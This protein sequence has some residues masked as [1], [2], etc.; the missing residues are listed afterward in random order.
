MNSLKYGYEFDADDQNNTAAAIFRAAT[1][2]GP[3]VLDLGSGPAIVSRRLHEEQGRDVTCVDSDAEALESLASSG[4]RTIRADLE[5][6]DWESQLS[7]GGYDVIILADVLEHLRDP[8]ALLQRI[9]R[10]NLLADGGL[11]LI[12]VPNAAH[13]SVIAELLLGDFRYMRTGILDA[14]HVRWFTHD[15]LRRLLE[16]NGF[17]ITTV[18]RT[19]RT[20]E[21]TASFDRA[22]QVPAD[23]RQRLRELNADCGTSQYVVRARRSDAA[24]QLA[25]ARETLEHHRAETFRASEAA[26]ASQQELQARLEQADAERVEQERAHSQALLSLSQE[27]DAALSRLREDLAGRLITAQ[28]ERDRARELLAEERE[29]TAHEMELGAAELTAIN[30]EMARLKADLDACRKRNRELRRQRAALRE[31]RAS[32]QRKLARYEGS[33]A[34]TLTSRSVWKLRRVVGKM[35]GGR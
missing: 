19:M 8:G 18:D 4:L 12:S 30:A 14:T 28:A 3:R 24:G 16:Q 5:S 7:S 1:A 26:R 23:V 13:E 25:A 2:A 6:D 20:L 15:S 33:R 9:T 32:Q 29:N 21:Q 22:L 11:M 31:T 10:A 27:H 35:R 17:I 34:I